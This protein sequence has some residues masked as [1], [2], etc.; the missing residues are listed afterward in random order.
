M[1]TANHFFVLSGFLFGVGITMMGMT[2]VRHEE[3]QSMQLEAIESECAR[4]DFK[5]GE[6]QWITKEE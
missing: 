6:F 4:Y 5:T 3:K 2:Y 1:N